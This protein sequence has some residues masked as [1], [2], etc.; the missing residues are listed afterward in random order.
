MNNTA[1]ISIFSSGSAVEAL[2]AALAS[3]REQLNSW[4]A[5][6]DTEQYRVVV[7]RYRAYFERLLSL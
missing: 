5:N 4:P 1:A 2:T 6:G 7:Q 3:H